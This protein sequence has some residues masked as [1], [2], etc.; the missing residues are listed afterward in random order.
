MKQLLKAIPLLLLA[1]CAGTAARQNLLLPALVSTWA[2][3]KVQVLRNTPALEPA[4]DA[5][6]QALEVGDPT[7]IA[8]VDWASLEMAAADDTEKRLQAGLIGLNV[9]VS[10]RNRLA[11]FT[12]SR[13]L[14]LRKP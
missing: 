8:A 14:Y 1:A 9:A 2:H 12:S 11:D 5:A 10:L 13:N 7:Q 4:A 3:I 6:S